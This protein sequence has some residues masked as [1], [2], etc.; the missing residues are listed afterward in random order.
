MITTEERRAEAVRCE[1]RRR[2]AAELTEDLRARDNTEARALLDA[3]DRGDEEQTKAL[4]AQGADPR[5]V[6]IRGATAMHMSAKTAVTKLLLAAG[7]ESSLKTCS[8]QSGASYGGP[9]V[10]MGGNTPLH[11]SAFSGHDHVIRTLLEGKAN[12]RAKNDNGDAPVDVAKHAMH[13]KI[14]R[15]LANPDEAV[16]KARREARDKEKAATAAKD[17]EERL[18]KN[19][20]RKK[21]ILHRRSVEAD[22]VRSAQASLRA[23]DEIRERSRVMLEHDE[24]AKLAPLKH[25]PS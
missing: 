6:G 7:A 1:A 13:Q 17:E 2:R 11:Y 25:Y 14:V 23:A 24:A 4:L 18:E 12:V 3:A 20:R 16:S 5:Y 19:A 15:M 8:K 10:S 21:E 22:A 9:P